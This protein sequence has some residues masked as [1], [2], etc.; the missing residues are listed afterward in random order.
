MGRRP[1]GSGAGSARPA[2]TIARP[3]QAALVA[4]AAVALVFLWVGSGLFYKMTG[5]GRVVS[6]GEEPVFFAHEAARFAGEPGMPDRFLS[7]HN[8]H[9]SLFEYYHGPERKVYTD[10]R[11]EV[12][13]ARPVRAVHRARQAVVKGLPGWEAELDEMGRPVIMVDHEHNWEIGATLFRSAH[14]RCVWFD[15]IVAVFVHD[16]IRVGRSSPC[17]RLRGP[18]FPSRSVD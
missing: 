4:F 17:R 10:P 7:F 16:S 5:E 12:A 1:S 11:L 9:A 18:A 6:L 15:A 13:G 3:A 2:A 8:G 14:W